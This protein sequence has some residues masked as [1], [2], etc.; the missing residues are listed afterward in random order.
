MKRSSLFSQIVA[1]LSR[2][3]PAFQPAPGQPRTFG[4]ALCQLLHSRRPS[5]EPQRA[6]TDDTPSETAIGSDRHGQPFGRETL[7]PGVDLRGA[8]LSGAD[9]TGARLF[10]AHL[11][12]ATLTDAR[13]PRAHLSGA[14]LT[15]ARL[16]GAILSGANLTDARLSRANLSRADL[17]GTDLTDARL[18]GANLI[19]ADLSGAHLSGADLSEVYLSGANLS[20]SNL[21]GADLSG[22]DLSRADLSRARLS[23]ANLS[24]AILTDARFAIMEPSADAVVAALAGA[25]WSE[26]TIWP[27]E[28]IAAT[29]AQS[30]RLLEDGY[31]EIVDDDQSRDHDYQ[32]ST[33][34]L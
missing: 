19:R 27:T 29:V 4:G 34:V 33:P 20:E 8:D 1:V 5:A 21:R 25:R 13:L 16:S 15:G 14:D 12:W 7:R 10:R 24:R 9:L 31:H 32:P 11:S 23:G 30:S 22:A 2:R 18:S 17:I 6:N 26:A 28:E 3:T